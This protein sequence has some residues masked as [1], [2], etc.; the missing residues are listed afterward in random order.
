MDK[1]WIVLDDVV[2]NPA[3]IIREFGDG[4]YDLQNECS[5]GEVR[6]VDGCKVVDTVLAREIDI[7]LRKA[8]DLLSIT[9]THVE[10]IWI[11]RYAVGGHYVWHGDNELLDFKERKLSVI[12]ALNDDY[13]GGNTEF[14]WPRP[15]SSEVVHLNPGSAVIFP[16]FMFHRALH[17]TSGERW[18]LIT[19]GVGEPF[20]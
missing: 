4:V 3:R 13:G 5:E 7:A 1:P 18:A 9:H 10:P 2:S 14:I 19:F 20:K 12:I 8:S 15:G 17:I 11:L 6:I 16:S